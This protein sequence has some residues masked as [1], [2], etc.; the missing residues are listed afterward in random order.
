VASKTHLVSSSHDLADGGLGVALLESCFASDLGAEV[1]LEGDPFVAL[2][3]ESTGR[4]LVTCD[5]SHLA[6]VK[7][8]AEK[9]SLPLS[10]LGRI[11]AEQQLVVTDLFT[12]DIEDVRTKWQL[13]I[14]DALGV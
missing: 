8:L 10:D 7:A 2:F 11:T 9:C 13:V 1:S 14:P 3:S 6:E 4:V 5:D 12:L